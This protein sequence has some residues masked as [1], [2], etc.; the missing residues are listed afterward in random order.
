MIDHHDDEGAIPMSLEG[1]GHEPR[2]IEKCGSCTS[3]VVR[4]LRD[5]W[6]HLS[7]AAL[8]S[9]A[10]HG[11]GDDGAVD[12]AAVVRVWDAQVAK[13]ALASIVIDTRNLTDASKTKETDREAVRYL[14]GKIRLSGKE[15]KEWNRGKF[16]E[17]IDKAKVDIGNLKL[18]DILRK[19]YKE[20]TEAGIKLGISSVV[21]P[22]EFL[23]GKAREE[24]GVGGKGEGGEGE[25]GNKNGKGA[26]ANKAFNK[27]LASFISTRKLVI[28]TIMTTST[29]SSG[30]FQ[31]QLLLQSSP[32]SSQAA[33]KFEKTA[34]EE[35]DLAPVSEEIGIRSYG[36]EGKED[37][38]EEEEGEG[39]RRVWQQR[40]VGASRKRVAPLLRKAMAAGGGDENK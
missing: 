16:Y 5:T 33:E 38:D 28:Y 25:D 34:T 40:N 2:V 13:M 20:W 9:G 39:W 29:S 27:A 32:E 22:L 37:K 4:E 24:A 21:K 18:E 1:E 15:G 7:S 35:L 12:D 6:D 14:E 19:D 23:V 8:S 10:S 30:S 36:G 17:E 11:Q 3:L 26:D 31:R